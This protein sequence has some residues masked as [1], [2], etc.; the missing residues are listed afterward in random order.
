MTPYMA[1]TAASAADILVKPVVI[2]N[3]QRSGK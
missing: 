2:A 1:R 3:I